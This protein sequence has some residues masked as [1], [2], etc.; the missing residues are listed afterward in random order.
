[1]SAIEGAARLDP[2]VYMAQGP[3]V[4]IDR[5]DV[6]A[7]VDGARR[8]GKRKSRLLLH[9]HSADSLHEMLIVHCRDEYIRPHRPLKTSKSY[10][11]VRGTMTI[12]LFEVDGTFRQA[13]ALGDHKRGGAFMARIM[14]PWFHT[15]VPTTETVAF[16]ETVPGPWLRTDYAPWAPP[17]DGSAAARSYHARLKAAA[18]PPRAKKP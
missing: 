17:A 18:R 9:P 2:E 7:L 11:V 13:I 12:V 4:E 15:L 3:I 5:A 14:G 10:H 16:I 6:D 8:S 1:M